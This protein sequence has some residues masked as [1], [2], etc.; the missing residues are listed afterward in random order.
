MRRKLAHLAYNVSQ[1]NSTAKPGRIVT[2]SVDD[3]NTWS[4]MYV[5]STRI[6]SSA[7]MCGER[8]FDS[9]ICGDAFVGTV[10][11]FISAQLHLSGTAAADFAEKH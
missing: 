4:Q 5:T 11:T 8:E 6:A 1:M 3:V 2:Q 9:Y 7:T 10:D